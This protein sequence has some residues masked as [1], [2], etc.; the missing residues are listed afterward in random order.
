MQ[1]YLITGAEDERRAEQ[2]ATA[3]YSKWCECKP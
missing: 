1:E 2:T 3:V